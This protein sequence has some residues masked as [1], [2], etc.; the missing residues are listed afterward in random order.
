M[1][2]RLQVPDAKAALIAAVEDYS[3]E[4]AV[5]VSH[6][7][8]SIIP[9]RLAYEFTRAIDY[10]EDDDDMITVYSMRCLSVADG[11]PP[12]Y[13]PTL[14]ELHAFSSPD[15]TEVKMVVKDEVQQISQDRITAVLS[16]LEFQRS[17]GLLQPT[18]VF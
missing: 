17:Q 5:W 4:A 8:S 7:R 18:N 1:S 14:F 9:T 15:E 16:D 11:V 2:E 12:Q 10:F 6:A 3:Y 13:A